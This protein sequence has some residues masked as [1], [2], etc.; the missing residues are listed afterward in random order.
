APEAAGAPGAFVFKTVSD[1]Y[2]GRLT[3]FRVL[4]GTFKSDGTYWNPGRETAERFGALFSPLGKQMNTV[5]EVP[6]GDIGGVAKLKETLTGDSLSAKDKPLVFP[7][8]DFA[9]P[10]ISFAIEPKSKGDEDKISAALHRVIEEDPSLRFS[11][12]AD[13]HEFLL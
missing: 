3:F 9:E 13:T 2:S 11:R 6:A 10:A 12:D 5:P 1:P 4:S 8:L 7:S